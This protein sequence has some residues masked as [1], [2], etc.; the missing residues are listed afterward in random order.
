MDI[1]D[2]RKLHPNT[3]ILRFDSYRDRIAK[4]EMQALDC[5]GPVHFESMD[6][7]VLVMDQSMDDSE[8]LLEQYGEEVPDTGTSPSPEFRGQFT[9]MVRGREYSGMQGTL[10][11]GGER[12]NFRS[13]L[14]LMRLL[15]EYLRRHFQRIS[16]G[17][18]I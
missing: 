14:E 12:K 11:H 16:A 1:S 6:H 9:V 7:L 4:G 2:Y 15:H 18:A 3:M 17:K 8:N 13:T 5:Q 10:L